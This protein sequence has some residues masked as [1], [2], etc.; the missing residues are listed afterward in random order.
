MRYPQG[1]LAE[2]VNTFAH[3]WAKRVISRAPTSQISSKNPE[4]CSH[5]L[6]VTP[7]KKCLIFAELGSR[8]K[9]CPDCGKELGVG[10]AK[11]WNPDCGAEFVAPVNAESSDPP[12]KKSDK[13]RQLEMEYQLATRGLGA[14]ASKTYAAMLVGF[15]IFL[16]T[17]LVL[18]ASGKQLFPGWP[19]VWVFGVIAT[20]VI[21]Y[22]SFAYGRTRN[23]KAEIAKEKKE[24]ELAA[25]KLAR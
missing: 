7:K 25:G 2:L 20:A 15:S 14:R 10:V 1:C 13:L 18:A 6:A 8:L 17:A 12:I 21:I 9:C 4:F 19:L 3:S 5:Y 24:L 22:Y 23:L 11:C 16:I